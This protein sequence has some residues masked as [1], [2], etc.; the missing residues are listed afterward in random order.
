[1][2]KSN[3]HGFVGD[4]MLATSL[5]SVAVAASVCNLAHR[6]AEQNEAAYREWDWRSAAEYWKS[7][8]LRAERLLAE[9]EADLDE[10]E[11]FD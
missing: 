8:A 6:R 4:A 2:P 10:L 9:A 1:M 5:L 7:R 3:D 11:G